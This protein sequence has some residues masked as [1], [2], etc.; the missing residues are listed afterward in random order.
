VL[1]MLAMAGSVIALIVQ[2]VQLVAGLAQAR[3]ARVDRHV[4]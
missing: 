2:F 3:E 1:L 4:P